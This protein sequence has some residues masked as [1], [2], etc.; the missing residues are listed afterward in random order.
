MLRLRPSMPDMPLAANLLEGLLLCGGRSSRMGRDKAELRLEGGSLLAR[1]LACL[2]Q[3]VV[4]VSLACGP[5]ERYREYGRP[6]VLDAIEDGG[7]LAGLLAGLEAARAERVALLAVDMPAVPSALYV[8]LHERAL[9]ADLCVAMLSGPDGDEPLCSIVHRR[10]APAVR[11]ALQA[12]E[13]RMVSFHADRVGRP[14]RVGRFTPAE[15][16]GGGATAQGLG[17]RSG[18]PLGPARNV[19]TPDEWRAWVER[20]ERVET[21]R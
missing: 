11:R 20:A 12:G 3:V 14:L 1:G 6:L 16:L 13:R 4:R 7:P 10:C 18:D 9:R 5:C 2:D 8:A 15:L 19:N 21:L 17:A